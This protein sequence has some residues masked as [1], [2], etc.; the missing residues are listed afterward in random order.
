M[1]LD[2]FASALIALLASAAMSAGLYA[3]AARQPEELAR[4]QRIWARAIVLAPAGWLLLE[5][6]RD[7]PSLAVAGK[8]LIVASFVEYL[9]ALLASRGRMPDSPWFA[10]PVCLV[11]VASALML[12]TQPGLPMR[13]GL[14]SVLCAGI[15]ASTAV[16]ALH[17]GRQRRGGNAGI[18]AAAFLM[19]AAVMLARGVLLFMPEGSAARVWIDQPWV[20]TLML[21]G[22]M[23]APAVASLGFVLMG[24]ERLLER[25]EGIASTDSLTGLLTRH[26]FLQRAEALLARPDAP[27]GA[28]LVVDLDHFKQINDAHGHDVGDQALRLVADAMRRQLRPG[29]LAGRHGGEEFTVFL[30]GRDAV[31]AE[32]VAEAMRSSVA[33]IG[34]L[35]DGEA[36]HLKVSIGVSAFGPDERDLA[37]LLKRADHAMYDAKRA[38]RD[39]VRVFPAGQA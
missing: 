26:A 30:P 6:A 12:F 31:E 7:L 37:G 21:G 35:A 24:S 29:D 3:A 25:L 14:L 16:V 4:P 34:L 15:A 27:I 1:N 2:P 17:G 5:W 38:G 10:A 33:H 28:L 19:C 32:A 13:T 39:Q 20:E 36:V 22:A 18:V 11:A 9:R 8:T 23:L